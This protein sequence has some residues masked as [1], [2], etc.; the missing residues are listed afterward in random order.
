MRFFQET[1][2]LSS[3]LA[4]FTIA[5]LIPIEG[6]DEERKYFIFAE[7]TRP[8]PACIRWGNPQKEKRR[9]PRSSL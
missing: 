5:V 3:V 6:K 4:R 8:S 7:R 1:M 2:N 9:Q